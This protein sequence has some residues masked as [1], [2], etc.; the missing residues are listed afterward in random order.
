VRG[1]PTAIALAVVLALASGAL[2]SGV[3]GAPP[4]SAPPSSGPPTEANL[5]GR[6]AAGAAAAQAWQ[7]PLDGAWTLYDTRRR[8][9]LK[10]QITDPA[11][12]GVLE[13]AWRAVGADAD[14]AGRAAATG[15]LETIARQGRRLTFH[16]TA[17]GGGTDT[18]VSLRQHGPRS[19]RGWM[20]RDGVRR[21]ATLEK[22]PTS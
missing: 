19:W 4:P 8:A 13:G 3:A 1:A 14:A 2:A 20:E 12:G 11:G 17:A 15:V 7:G 22:E 18:R 5:G 6:I 10:L 16:L 9:I 21:P